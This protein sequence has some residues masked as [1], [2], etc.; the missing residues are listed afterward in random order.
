MHIDWWTL[1]LQA[2]NVLILVWLLSR[3]LFRPV[4]DAIAARQAAADRLLGEAQAA[5]DAAKGEEQALK[6]RN[7]GF[8]ADTERQRVQ[9]RAGIEAERARLLEQARAEADTLTKQAHAATAVERARLAGE[10]EEKAATLAGQMA[11]RLLQRLP[12]A[13]TTEA[14][15]DALLDRLR[16]LPEDGRRKLEQDAPLTIATPMAVS[17]EARTRYLQQL[18]IVLPGAAA[19]SFVVEPGLIAGFELHGPHMRIHNSWRAD[20]DA[21]VAKLREDDHAR[22][23]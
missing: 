15:F 20:L 10:L 13:A 6:A 21:M 9:I 16:T 2:I 8:A 19:P 23:G 12:P 22:T 1:A 18:A 14:M 7:D 3:F 11:E 17:D 4:M 5:K